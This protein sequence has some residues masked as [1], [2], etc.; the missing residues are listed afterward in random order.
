[1][2]RI[3]RVRFDDNYTHMQQYTNTSPWLAPLGGA[4][5]RLLLSPAAGPPSPRGHAPLPDPADCDPPDKSSEEQIQTSTIAYTKRWRCEVNKIDTKAINKKSTKNKSK[6][7]RR[8]AK[9]PDG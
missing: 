3:V 8:A 4:T 1:M 6:E 2:E 9:R 5:S 7:M